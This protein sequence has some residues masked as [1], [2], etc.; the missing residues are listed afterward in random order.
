VSVLPEAV[1]V[2]T[3]RSFALQDELERMVGDVRYRPGPLSSDELVPL[4]ADADGLLAG[5]DEIDERVF[6]SA[7]RLRVVARYGVG[8][9][10]VD[11]EAARRHGVTVTV[12][13]GAN[14]N[15]VAELT[16]AL[17]F[18]LA[19]PLV[20]GRDVVESG[21][22]RS[23]RGIELRGRTLGIVGLGR[24]GSL[25]AEKARALGMRVLACDPYAA[26]GTVSLD[27][28]QAQA[29]FVSLHAPLTDET[30]GLV[31]DAFLA[32]LKP[33]VALVNTARGELVD[34]AALLAALDA[35][36]L[37]AALDVLAH[38]P[39]SGD[40]PLLHRDDVLVTPHLGAATAEAA[41]AMGRIAVEELL[42][43]LSGGEAR[44]AV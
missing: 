2:V 41:E 33:G 34:E 5:V 44:Y 13:P 1:V 30:R 42:A 37:R 14:A 20:Q 19:R 17:L 4:V 16:I 22:W 31:D 3:P 26:A 18:A 11:L 15:A 25:V 29:D 7:P 10:R 27:E 32:R 12:T 38:E 28:L 35:G 24:V 21:E 40:D 6:S 43:V 23:L 8:L 36:L 9:D 39:P